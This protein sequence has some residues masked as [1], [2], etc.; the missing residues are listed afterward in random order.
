MVVSE[1]ICEFSS[2]AEVNNYKPLGF[3]FYSA[4][5]AVRARSITRRSSTAT[6]WL[7][8]VITRFK[9]PLT[10]RTRRFSECGSSCGRFKH[11]LM[12]D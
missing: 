9:R 11:L 1:I 10:N 2:A 4:V 5:W 8:G 12:K 7:L 3:L 6:C